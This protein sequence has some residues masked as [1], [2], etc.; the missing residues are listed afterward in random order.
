MCLPSQPP[1]FPSPAFCVF[2]LFVAYLLTVHSTSWEDGEEIHL[3]KCSQI[4][5]QRV[6]HMKSAI[7]KI[8][9]QA[10]TCKDKAGSLERCCPFPV[11]ISMQ[12]GKFIVC[13]KLLRAKQIDQHQRTGAE[14]FY[15]WRCY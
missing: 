14:L 2:S 6:T 15:E 8:H 11:Y 3:A 12:E 10:P 7:G 13:W 1:P 4:H 5:L 9:S